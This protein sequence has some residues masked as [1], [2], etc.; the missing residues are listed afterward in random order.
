MNRDDHWLLV[1]TDVPTVFLME[2]VSIGDGLGLLTLFSVEFEGVKWTHVEVDVVDFVG[3]LVVAGEDCGAHELLLDLLL[4]IESASALDFLN[5]RE[6][7]I[8]SEHFM[9]DIDVEKD[10]VLEQ[11]DG[12]REARPDLDVVLVQRL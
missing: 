7:R 2:V 1:F 12:R 5:Q 11:V 4:R 9:D 10:T 3:A 8:C 6:H